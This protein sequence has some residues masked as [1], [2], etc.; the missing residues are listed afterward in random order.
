MSMLVQ[1]H[2]PTE[3]LALRCDL[4]CYV[5]VDL[6]NFPANSALFPI[7]CGSVIPGVG[8]LK[9]SCYN[10]HHYLHKWCVKTTSVQ[11]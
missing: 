2:C 7:Y 10:V 3:F 9:H 5:K 8:T 4:L 11:R 1:K 6:F